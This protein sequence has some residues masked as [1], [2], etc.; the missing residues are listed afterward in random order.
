[1]QPE[2]RNICFRNVLF[3]EQLFNQL[4][5]QLHGVKG[6]SSMGNC[7]GRNVTAWFICW[8]S[9]HFARRIVLLCSLF[10]AIIIMGMLNGQQRCT[11]I[12]RTIWCTLDWHSFVNSI[13][14]SKDLRPSCWIVPDVKALVV[15]RQRVL[16]GE[17][18][19]SG[20]SIFW[21][22]LVLAL[23]V[24][25]KTNARYFACVWL[26]SRVIVMF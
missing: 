11:L 6:K 19:V 14:M 8:L 23:G 5:S 16:N 1:M 12:Y 7:Q 25:F 20:F 3:V 2:G 15:W 17:H 4:L 21:P 9:V 22:L 18:V 10:L 26:T 24:L 13:R